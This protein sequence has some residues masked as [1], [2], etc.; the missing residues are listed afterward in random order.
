MLGLKLNNVS[1]RG[2]MATLP[3]IICTHGWVTAIWVQLQSVRDRYGSILDT[4]ADAGKGVKIHKRRGSEMAVIF[5]TVNNTGFVKET[6]PTGQGWVHIVVTWSP[7]YIRLYFGG[8]LVVSKTFPS[9]SLSSTPVR[10]AQRFVISA[11]DKYRI[12]CNGTLDG[13]HFWDAVMD[14]EDVLALYHEGS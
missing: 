3:F 11:T 9:Q 4:G 2:P 10:D 14:G 8:G 12:P 5:R 1:K 7:N 6:A 13:L